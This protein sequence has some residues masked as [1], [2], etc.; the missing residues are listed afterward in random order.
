MSNDMWIKTE[1]INCPICDS[2][3]YEQLAVR[4]DG[5]NIVQCKKCGLGY[6][7]PRPLEQE[8]YKLYEKDY[9]SDQ[10][11]ERIIYKGLAPSIHK[12]K[13][14][15]PY[16]IDILTSTIS[17]K[18]KRALDIGCSHGK[19]VYWMQKFGAN[20][21]GIDL[22]QQCV[23][24]G[25]DNMGLDLR[26]KEMSSLDEPDE[27][28]EQI[29][30]I[31]LIEHVSDIRNFM[32]SLTRKLKPGGVVFVQTP[33]LESYYKW[34]KQWLFLDFG[35]EHL[36]YFSAA[37]L[38]KLFA[39]YGMLPCKQTFVL[40]TIPC[41]IKGSL[42]DQKGFKRKLASYLLHLPRCFEFVHK[43]LSALLASEYKYKYDTE[44]KSGAILVGCYV[45]SSS[46]KA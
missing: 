7:N 38:D 12:I 6:L 1:N 30:M 9:Y 34:Q 40:D 18:N 37:T 33:N 25:R 14:Y 15:K 41:D 5:L 43:G 4:T 13:Y 46:V 29:T 42:K 36:L 21:I 22:G 16:T 45:K 31:D 19:W 2:K 23:E 11:D 20:A 35:L 10:L 26:Q 32:E 44:R 8:L 39:A 28:F 17:L 3:E 24:W 27:S